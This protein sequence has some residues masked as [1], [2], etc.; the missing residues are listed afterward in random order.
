MPTMLIVRMVNSAR[1]PS[2]EIEKFG[3]S[4]G[5]FASG[6]SDRSILKRFGDFSGAA[7]R[8]IWGLSAG[9]RITGV[10]PFVHGCLV[11]GQGQTWKSELDLYYNFLINQFFWAGVGSPVRCLAGIMFTMRSHSCEQADR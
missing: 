5:K 6:A 2:G 10:A 3:G 9:R 11:M 8:E 1:L 4:D 7:S